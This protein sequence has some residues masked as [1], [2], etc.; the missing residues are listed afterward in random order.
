MGLFELC[1]PRNSVYP[2]RRAAWG[3]GDVKTI[4]DHAAQHSGGRRSDMSSFNLR[5]VLLVSVAT[6]VV[7]AAASIAPSGAQE[8]VNPP[9]FSSNNVGWVGL[10]GNGPFFE[11]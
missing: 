9:D 3:C 2:T 6:A 5:Q 11:P 8:K 7:L 4:W 1:H 10:N